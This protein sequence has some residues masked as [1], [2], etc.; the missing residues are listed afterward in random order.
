MFA[1]KAQ[2]RGPVSTYGEAAAIKG[3][4]AFCGQV[5]VGAFL[6]WFGTLQLDAAPLHP[7]LLR[8]R[9]LVLL[10]QLQGKCDWWG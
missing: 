10:R 9:P 1:N 4:G 6:I 2:L 3:C 5:M 8:F 7:R